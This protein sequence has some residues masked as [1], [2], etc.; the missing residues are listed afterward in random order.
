MYDPAPCWLSHITKEALEIGVEPGNDLALIP[1]TASPQGEGPTGHTVSALCVDK[2]MQTHMKFVKQL[3][4]GR[5]LPY[6]HQ[7]P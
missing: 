4:L 3:S 2:Y 1:N 7:F 6:Y 5:A